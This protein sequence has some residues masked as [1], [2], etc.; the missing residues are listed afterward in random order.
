MASELLQAARH[1]VAQAAS[2]L[3]RVAFGN[4]GSAFLTSISPLLNVSCK[5]VAGAVSVRLTV[6]GEVG[7]QRGGVAAELTV[8]AT[9][10]QGAPLRL[11]QRSRGVEVLLH[12]LQAVG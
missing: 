4:E 12:T 11:G 5:L 6:Q 8:A 1:I 7:P 10:N 3:D 9:G 2:Q